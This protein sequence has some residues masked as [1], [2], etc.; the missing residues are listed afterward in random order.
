MKSEELEV[1]SRHIP[2]I[3]RHQLLS[4][5]VDQYLF[6]GDRDDICIAPTPSIERFHGS[7]LFVDISGFTVL[8]QKLGVEDLKR[9]INAY[10]TKIIDIIDKYDGEVVKFAGDALF[11]I[12]QTRTNVIGK[13]KH[14]LLYILQLKINI[15]VP[16]DCRNY[17]RFAVDDFETSLIINVY[18]MTVYILRW[19]CSIHRGI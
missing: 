15:H 1:F 3:L 17:S 19:E 6:L 8:S 10:F 11:I 9:Q 18:N 2:R 4:K 7:M 12:W 14:E 16:V 5:L 13:L